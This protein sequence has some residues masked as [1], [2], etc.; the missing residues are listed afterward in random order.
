MKRELRIERI[1]DLLIKMGLDGC[2][3]KG[4]DNIFYLTGFKG[5]EGMLFVTRG[6]VVLIVDFRYITHAREV[7][8]GIHIYEI[9]PG[10]DAL[11]T[12][13]TRYNVSKLGFD[14]AYI[15]YNTYKTWS[16][17]LPGTSLVP[18]NSAID[19]IRKNKEPEET[20]AIIDAISIA[21]AAFT[22]IIGLIKPGET[23][24]NIADELDY[25]MRK[26][27]AHGPSFDTIVASGPRA[28][29][30]HAEPTTRKLQDGET[31]II[32]FGAIV[33]GYCSDETVTL[34][35]G[36]IPD[37]MTDIFTIVN[38][39]RKLGIEKAVSGTPIKQ[40]DSM[41][42]G[43]IEDK[44]YGD[45]F[46]HGVGHGVGIAVHEAPA[47]NSAAQGIL[48]ENMV[49]TIEPGIYLPNIG[50]VR[51][52]D[53]ILITGDTPRILTQIRKDMIKI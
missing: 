53:M 34:C 41:V 17:N 3:L 7:T 21:T 38:D 2:V 49:I 18:M 27:G 14:G 4:M 19:E 44:G 9:K 26:R 24:K 31:V 35:L 5:S 50:G 39:A 23:E 16:E 48:E 32:D 12:L 52:E 36:D 10:N 22:D 11:H 51:L 40:L 1:Q 8:N 47:V 25:R 28:A 42:R 30:P 33:S 29:L 15:P 13:C 45:Y 6:D 20:A 46:R 43:Y 37:K